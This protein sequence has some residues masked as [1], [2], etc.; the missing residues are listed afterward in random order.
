MTPAAT[1]AV[2]P[3]GPTA[4]ARVTGPADLT[5]A[6][7]ELLGF[8]PAESLVVLSLHE[9]RGRV[10]LTM[11]FDLAEARVLAREVPV[12]LRHE[13]ATRAVLAVW[14]DEPGP[15]PRAG[16]VHGVVESV[17]AAG[18]EVTAA[19]LVRDGTWWS[20]TCTGECCPAQGLPVAGTRTGAAGLMAAERVL[21][22]DVLRA[23]RA[24]LE[25][26]MGCRL[27][28][29]EAVRCREL[30]EA[31]LAL[32]DDIATDRCRTQER[33]VARLRK[34]LGADGRL[35]AD[36][37]ARCAVA[38]RLV[39]VRDEVLTWVGDSAPA[40]RH[41][42]L[43]LCR[44]TP[45]RDVVPTLVVLGAA[46]YAEG[47]GAT[48]RLALERALRLDPACTMAGLLLQALD[49]QVPPGQVRDIL[50]PPARR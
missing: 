12:R 28:L 30:D 34:A 45:D 6:I 37:A 4:V 26:A 20:Y 48:A 13:R 7:P 9:P 44:W 24:E 38:L 15:L 42:A 47:G 11:R 19:L 49:G 40:V 14:T 18:I 10:G 31:A 29:G 46:A 5:A 16:L 35:S 41:L 2:T 36:D 8:V 33:E 39:S 22:G 1:P 25:Q 23:S 17:E 43:A 32:L 50:R 27:P 3:D 21:R